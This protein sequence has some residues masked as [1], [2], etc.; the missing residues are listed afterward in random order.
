[1]RQKGVPTMETEEGAIREGK[2]ETK[3]DAWRVLGTTEE[4]PASLSDAE[5]RK[6]EIHSFICSTK[7]Y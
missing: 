6:S 3:K 7:I 5:A 1:M 2:G 4:E